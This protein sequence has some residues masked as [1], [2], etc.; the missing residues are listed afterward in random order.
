[1]KYCNP[2]NHN[3]QI[4]QTMSQQQPHIKFNP[5]IQVNNVQVNNVAQYSVSN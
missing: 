1:M 2:C 3:E 5:I 4:I